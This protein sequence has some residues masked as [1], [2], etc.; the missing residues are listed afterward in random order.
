MI[1]EHKV[2]VRTYCIYI[3]KILQWGDLGMTF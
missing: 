1:V 2:G 3:N